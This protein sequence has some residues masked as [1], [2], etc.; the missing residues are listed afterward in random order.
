VRVF[1]GDNPLAIAQAIVAGPQRLAGIATDVRHII[2]RATAQEPAQR[3][4]SI[5]DMRRDLELVRRGRPATPGRGIAGA[6][7]LGRWVQGRRRA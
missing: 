2:E 3:Y 5:D 4:P 7:E 6:A 1:V